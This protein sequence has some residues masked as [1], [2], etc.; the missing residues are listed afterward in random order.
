M[1]PSGIQ[2]TNP[3][4]DGEKEILENASITALNLHDLCTKTSLSTVQ[5]DM[6]EILAG[7]EKSTISKAAPPEK[8]KWLHCVVDTGSWIF[9]SDLLNDDI[10]HHISV[11][12]KSFESAYI[13]HTWIR[14]CFARR[15][16]VLQFC[17]Y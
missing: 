5:S 12:T 4:R 10:I 15:C 13:I 8:K 17:D 9:E 2:K 14:N 16:A 3:A 11:D 1:Q 6:F 7:M